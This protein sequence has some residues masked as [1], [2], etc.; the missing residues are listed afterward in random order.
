[1]GPVAIAGIVFEILQ[2]WTGALAV[3]PATVSMVTDVMQVVGDREEQLTKIACIA[4]REEY[5][6]RYRGVTYQSERK[7]VINPA[8]DHV[9][10]TKIWS[11]TTGTQPV[12][13]A[14]FDFVVQRKN[15][16]CA[17][18]DGTAVWGYH[19]WTISTDL[20]IGYEIATQAVLPMNRGPDSI[21]VAV[22][23]NGLSTPTGCSGPITGFGLSTIHSAPRLKP[24]GLPM[25]SGNIEITRMTPTLRR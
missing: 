15:T 23:W 20:V 5:A 16:Y 2:T 12:N 24:A 18:N 4:Y 6:N 17:F 9:Y 14:P 21:P 19:R 11:S 7:F 22:A 8:G 13:N 25:P 3:A 10:T 1:M